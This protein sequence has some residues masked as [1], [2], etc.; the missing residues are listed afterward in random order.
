MTADDAA[1]IDIPEP[2][3]Q[4]TQQILQ[5]PRWRRLLV[6]GDKDRGKSTYCRYLCQQLLASGETVAYVDADVGQK[7]IGPPAA[8]TL[9]YPQHNTPWA[10][11]E[12]AGWYF[13]GNVT[14]VRQLLPAVLGTQRLVETA[15][16]DRTVINTVGFVHRVGRVLLTHLI[17]AIRPDVIIALAKG[18]E[19][20][21][22]L[23][24]YRDHR[25]LRLPPSPYAVAK[26]QPERQ[27]NRERAFRHYFRS[28]QPIEL[29]LKDL[30]LQRALLF[31]GTRIQLPPFPYAERTDE[32]VLAVAAPGMP[33]PSHVKAIPL[34]FERHLLCG[35][36]NRRGQGLGLGILQHIDFARDTMALLTPV[37]ASHIRMLQF[38]DIAVSPDGREIG[39][40][41]N[42]DW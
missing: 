41:E 9:G 11:I 38:G 20:S 23:K 19:L 14:P 31:T 6:L 27:G 17:E 37:G 4:S 40:R 36:S 5:Q 13:V 35:L 32:G 33:V 16:A 8:I 15:Q 22:I 25:T 7:D 24:P 21:A 34:G 10:Q 18:R 28:T 2:W 1:A 29:K 42:R 12:T 3:A 39:R 26:T 30:V